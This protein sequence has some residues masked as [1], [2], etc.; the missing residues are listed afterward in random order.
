M[1]VLLSHSLEATVPMTEIEEWHK[2]FVPTMVRRIKE[3]HINVQATAEHIPTFYLT[4]EQL[5]LEPEQTLTDMFQFMLGVDS[6]EGTV[7]QQRIRDSVAQGSQSKAVYTLKFK[8]QANNLS[9]HRSQ[10]TDE[11]I[12]LMKSE[13]RESLFFFGFVKLPDQEHS[14]QFFDYDDITDEDMARFGKFRELN[15]ATLAACAGKAF[16]GKT[17]RCNKDVQGEWT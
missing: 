4:Y 3:F 2:I 6:L 1:V 8:D 12:A 15:K 14:T 10:Y 9:R 16:D 5:I 17:Y 11:E 13:L 7:L